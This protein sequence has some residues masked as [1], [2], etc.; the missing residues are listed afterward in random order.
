MNMR[1]Y[2]LQIEIDWERKSLN[3]ERV[4]R[5]LEEAKP[6]PGSLVVLP[7]MFATGFSMNV[8]AANDS[9][10]M[11]TQRFLAEAA[12]AHGVFLMGGVVV[13]AET[14]GRGLNQC[15]IYDPQG[16]EFARYSKIRP[17]TL[18][19]EADHYDAGERVVRFDW[20]GFHVSPFICY[21]L[22]FPELFR[23]A[24]AGGANLFTVIANWPQTRVGHWEALLK[25]RAIENQAYVVGVNRSGVDPQSVYPGR[26]M[27]IA[28]GGEVIAEAGPEQCIMSADLD[29]EALDRYRRDLPF[30][31]DLHRGFLRT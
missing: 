18:G 10:S 28:P 30:L 24:A 22:R 6:A 12:A 2:C 23:A 26:S 8:A 16:A 19:G 25:A 20:G 11:E 14:S 9:E 4:S 13:V 31:A 7:E 27:I 1:V 3:H 5:L 17:F 29:R 15:V 21:D